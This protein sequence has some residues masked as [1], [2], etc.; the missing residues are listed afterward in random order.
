MRWPPTHGSP[1]PVK[2]REGHRWS[3]DNNQAFTWIRGPPSAVVSCSTSVCGKIAWDRRA[4]KPACKAQ[5]EAPQ[6]A[7]G[8]GREYQK[9]VFPE[10]KYVK[11]MN[12]NHWSLLSHPA[13]G[14]SFQYK[15]HSHL[16]S[17]VRN[18]GSK[19][20]QRGEF[21]H[22]TWEEAVAIHDLWLFYCLWIF[23]FL[24]QPHELAS[25]E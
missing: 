22:K 9:V 20:H 5:Q 12:G 2:M 1:P 10:L 13:W 24:V 19:S 14:M 4:D 17:P 15:F 16:C 8:R 25:E 7:T 18:S 3:L 23:I 11:L 21:D 6:C